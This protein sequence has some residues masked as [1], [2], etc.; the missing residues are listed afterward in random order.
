MVDE[1][2]FS[3]RCLQPSCDGC[4]S[5]VITE[6]FRAAFPFVENKKAVRYHDLKDPCG[7]DIPKLGGGNSE[8]YHTDYSSNYQSRGFGAYKFNFGRLLHGV[9]ETDARIMDYALSIGMV[10]KWDTNNANLVGLERHHASRLLV[11]SRCL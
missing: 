7:N 2:V 1:T 4:D 8:F 6:K 5:S 11:T 10:N 3:N 9:G